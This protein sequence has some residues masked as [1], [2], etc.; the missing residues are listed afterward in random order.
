VAGEVVP[1][2]FVVHENG[3]R[4]R[5]DFAAGYSQGLFLDQRENRRRVRELARPGTELLN[6]FAYTCA[7]S[8]CAAAGG[9][10][11]VSVDLSKPSLDWGRRNFEATARPAGH[12]SSSPARRPTGSSGSGKKGRQFDAIVL[13]PPT[14]SRDKKGKVFRVERD[15]GTLAG[16]RWPSC[17][18]AGRCCVRRTSGR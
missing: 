13:D 12:T 16:R 1:E 3:V 17:G 18:R 11:T 5:I 7:F 14:F 4:Y 6:L 15:F 8:V 2:P 10:H 9:G